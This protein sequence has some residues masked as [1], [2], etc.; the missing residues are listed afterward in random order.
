[1]AS[2]HDAMRLVATKYGDCIRAMQATHGLLYG[3]KQVAVIHMANQVRDHLGV[4]L[5]LKDK[6]GCLQLGA[7][8]LVI[9]NNAVMYQGNARFFGPESR[10]VW[11]GV[12]RDRCTV[13]RPAGVSNTGKARDMVARDVRGQLSN[14]VCA[15]RT[16]Q[17]TVIVDCHPTRVITAIL[18]PLKAFNQDWGDITRSDRTNDSAHK[19]SPKN[20]AI[21]PIFIGYLFHKW[22]RY[23]IKYLILIFMKYNFMN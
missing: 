23:D 7:Q 12:A 9:F 10:E 19:A 6:A 17:P 16:A 20:H 13:R 15:A 21:V 4:G 3:L 18:E 11:V 14:P 2:R 5:A 22:L 1:M 8:R